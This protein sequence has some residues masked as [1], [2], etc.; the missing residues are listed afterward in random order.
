MR[1]PNT[2]CF[3]SLAVPVMGSMTLRPHLTMGL[4]FRE[5][6]EIYFALP[7]NIILIVHKIQADL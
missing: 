3:G 1:L 5:L 2:K 7:N 6:K 4:P